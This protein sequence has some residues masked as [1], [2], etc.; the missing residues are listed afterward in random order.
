[1]DVMTIMSALCAAP[2][3]NPR[4]DERW[5][6]FLFQSE[7]FIKLGALLLEKADEYAPG[8]PGSKANLA[9]TYCLFLEAKAA[10][11][12]NYE[13]LEGQYPYPSRHIEIALNLHANQIMLNE[14]KISNADKDLFSL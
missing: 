14:A 12:S 6:H 5:E 10:L 9:K 3:S 1:M 8:E 2:F 4:A 7:A 13:D 11:R